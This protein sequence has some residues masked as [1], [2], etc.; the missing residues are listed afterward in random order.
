MLLDMI[1][2]F[3]IDNGRYTQDALEELR[4]AIIQHM[5]YGTIVVMHDTVGIYGVTRF[6][7]EGD[8]AYIMDCAVRKDKR[9]KGVLKEMTKEGLIR[10]PQIKRFR[11]ERVAKNQPMKYIKIDK[12]KQEK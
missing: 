7:I 9:F 2:Q 5:I 12:F 3:L 6:N 8:T 1:A 4:Q 11:F 10:F